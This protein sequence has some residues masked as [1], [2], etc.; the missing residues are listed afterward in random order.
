VRL[1]LNLDLDLNLNR[2]SY[3]ALNPKPHVKPFE[4]SFKKPNVSPY[5]STSRFK[6]RP[7]EALMSAELRGQT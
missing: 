6:Y 2:W 3:L 4:K 5:V 1:H 7:F